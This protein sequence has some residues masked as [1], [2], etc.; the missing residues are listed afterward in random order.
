MRIPRITFLILLFSASIA[1]AGS[2][3]STTEAAKHIGERA[4]VCGDIAGEH[5]A[6]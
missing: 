4:T 1:W 3:L 6:P 2:I 5:T